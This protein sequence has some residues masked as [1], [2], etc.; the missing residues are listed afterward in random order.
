MEMRARECAN[1]SEDLTGA[2]TPYATA[3][4]D[5]F[6]HSHCSSCFC[7]LPMQSPCVMSCVTCCSV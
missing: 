3:L 1:M 7:E 5:A 4:H 6:F 2:I